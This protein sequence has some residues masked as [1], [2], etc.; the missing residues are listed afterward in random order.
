M[1]KIT[2]LGASGFV[3]S[4]LVKKIE[5]MQIDAFLP[6]KGDESIFE[7]NLNNVI[8]CIGMTAD[9]RTKPFE[10]VEAHV[11]FLAKV[12]EKC[13]FDSFL[14]LSSARIYIANNLSE[15]ATEDQPISVNPV[16]DPNDLYNISKLMGESLCLNCN[17]PGVRIARLSNVFGSDFDS[18]NFLTDILKDIISKQKIVLRTS[19]VSEKDYISVDD[20]CYLLLKVLLSGKKQVYNIVSGRNISNN[21]ILNKIREFMPFDLKVV[22]DA[23][24]IKFPPI[25]NERVKQEFDFRPTKTLLEEIPILIH[26]Y[27]DAMNV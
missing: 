2:V 24:T 15:V 26:A 21:Q 22:E 5:K 20:V 8:Y 14:Y 3:G 11:S 25:S 13:K 16:T 17:K 18:S 6:A 4:N 1:Q 10:T 19:L 12:L 23:P 7:R 9:F 27:Q